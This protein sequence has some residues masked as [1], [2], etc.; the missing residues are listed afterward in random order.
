SPCA[1]VPIAAPSAGSTPTAASASSTSPSVL[2]GST[3]AACTSAR[4]APSRG[5]RHPRASGPRPSSKRVDSWASPLGLARR[6]LAQQGGDDLAVGL[7][8]GGLHGL[9]DEEAHH[10]LVAALEALELGGVVGDEPVDDR[11]QGILLHGLEAQLGGDGSRVATPFEHLRQDLLG[12]RCRQLAVGLQL[13][14]RGQGLG[15]EVGR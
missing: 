3:T 7:A 14:E 5:T 2:S 9:A 11:R 12:L 1:A 10:L 4:A 8:L 15:L 6:P 13:H